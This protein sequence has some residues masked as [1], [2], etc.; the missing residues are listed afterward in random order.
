[1]LELKVNTADGFELCP[2]DA[3][4]IDDTYCPAGS[5]EPNRFEIVG[6][7][8]DLLLL[9]QYGSFLRDNDIE[10]A[11]IE[12]ITDSHGRQWTYDVNTNTNYNRAAEVAA[13]ASAPRTLARFLGMLIR[14][15]TAY[16][17]RAS[18]ERQQVLA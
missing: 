9:K 11:G 18:E 15:S 13:G 1:M 10:V 5:G 4:Q 3:C 12:F 17:W 6:D 16:H 2:A 8:D 14:L 7:F